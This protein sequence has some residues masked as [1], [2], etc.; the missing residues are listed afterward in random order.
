MIREG[1]LDHDG[2]LPRVIV[3]GHTVTKSLMPEVS[4]WRIA[5]DTGAYGSGQ[6]TCLAVSED[7][8]N[9]H[10]IFAKTEGGCIQIERQVAAYSMSSLPL[11]QI[12]FCWAHRH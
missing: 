6:L 11:R 2:P 9:L 5:I 12:A 3:H 4:P 1:L 10:F 7:E 8:R